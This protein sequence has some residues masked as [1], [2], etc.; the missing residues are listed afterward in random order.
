MYSSKQA[1][2]GLPVLAPGSLLDDAGRPEAQPGRI[3][4]PGRS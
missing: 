1:G 3:A 2:D 4:G